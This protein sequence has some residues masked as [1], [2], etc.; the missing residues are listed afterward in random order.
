MVEL[1]AK[2]RKESYKKQKRAFLLKEFLWLA[3]TMFRQLLYKRGVY[4]LFIVF[5][6]EIYFERN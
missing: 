5:Y 1:F 6:I 4:T 3:Y 2:I